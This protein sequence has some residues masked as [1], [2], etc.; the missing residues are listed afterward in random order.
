[1]L[2]LQVRAPDVGLPLSLAQLEALS[3]PVLVSRLVA[4]R[5]YLL[6][7]RIAEMLGAG[8]EQVQRLLEFSL[9]DLIT[10]TLM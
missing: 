6:A 5:R 9:C 1:M 3:L 2:N 10:D 4:G 7:F 8:Q